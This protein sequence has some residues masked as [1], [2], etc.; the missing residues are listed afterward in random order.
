MYTIA[1][2][3]NVKQLTSSPLDLT[4]IEYL[5]RFNCYAGIDNTNGNYIYAMKL[6][7][8]SVLPEI[9]N[10]R[11]RGV[12][13]QLL[14]DDIEHNLI[15][16][17]NDI[18][19]K[20]V[21]ILFI[22]DIINSIS[23]LP[24]EYEAYIATIGVISKWK[25]LFDR[26]NT[27]CLSEEKVKGLWG[28]LHVLKEIILATKD[29]ILSIG[30]WTGWDFE[31]KDFTH[32]NKA[33]EVKFSTSKVTHLSISSERQLDLFSLDI[34]F[35]KLIVAKKV[36]SDGVTLNQLVDQIEELISIDLEATSEFEKRLHKTGYNK[37]EEKE[38]SLS[39]TQYWVEEEMNYNIKND[40]P[41]ITKLI[42]PEG[43][44]QVNYQIELSACTQYLDSNFQYLQFIN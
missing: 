41:K 6:P 43:I 37:L 31:D 12:N 29:P 27:S 7:I 9:K 16:V 32:K 1:S 14:S 15:I 23:D 10:N 3:W 22:D 30:I 2:I 40:F 4:R 38:S 39:N 17:L 11:F 19:I 24:T 25:K 21:F 13:I 5:D 44:F 42:L 18:E 20:D 34:L 28:E 33:L 8:T 35:L 26:I 36:K